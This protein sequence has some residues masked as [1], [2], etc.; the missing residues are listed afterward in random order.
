MFKPQ[1]FEGTKTENWIA[2][3]MKRRGHCLVKEMNGGLVG[4]WEEMMGM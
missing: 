1:E 3:L 4:I 2:F